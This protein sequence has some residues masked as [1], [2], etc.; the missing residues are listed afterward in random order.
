MEIENAEPRLPVVGWE[1]LYEVST[2]GRTAIQAVVEVL[3][4]DHWD[5]V[6]HLEDPLR[7][8]PAEEVV[9]GPSAAPTAARSGPANLAC[10]GRSMTW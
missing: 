7:V 2:P 5:R 1:D 10:S 3:R 4:V 8:L 9:T 6:R